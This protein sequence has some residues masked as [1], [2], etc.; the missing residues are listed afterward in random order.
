MRYQPGH[1]VY[2]ASSLHKGNAS[3]AL[4]LVVQDVEETRDGI[5]ALLLA[6]GYRVDTA[7]HE[8]D[9][10]MRA[11]RRY[12]DLILV[13]LGQVAVEVIAAA[14]RIRA[15]A[16]L[17]EEVPVVILCVDGVGEGDEVEIGQEVYVTHPDNFNQLRGL[18]GRLVHR[19]LARSA[20]QALE[21]VLDYPIALTHGRFQAWT[22]E[23]RDVPRE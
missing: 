3:G 17:S 2:M 12:P 4:I 14:R 8:K 20:E 15:R 10:V 13:N 16:E 22:V 19:R 18:L 5:E 9:A 21:L 1:V 23:D 6:D 7:R 11:Q